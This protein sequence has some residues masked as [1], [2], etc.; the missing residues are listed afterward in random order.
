MIEDLIEDLI[1]VSNDKFKYKKPEELRNYYRKVLKEKR[2]LYLRNNGDVVGYLIYFIFD[3]EGL[4]RCLN[5]KIL[6]HKPD[7]E[8]L[9]I[10]ENVVFTGKRAN[11][12][13]LR[14]LFKQMY[15]QLKAV[16]WDN[17]ITKGERKTKHLFKYSEE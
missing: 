11:Y 10:D 6:K 16:Y 17:I 1:T 3:K 9:Y 13:Y 5:D 15:P 14:K 7:G 12:L 4:D 8:Y 2:L